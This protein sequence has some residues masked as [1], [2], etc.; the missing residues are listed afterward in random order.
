MSQEPQ[1]SP[2]DQGE[3][4]EP[5]LTKVAAPDHVVQLIRTSGF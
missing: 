3:P 5:L 1:L 2:A 4:W